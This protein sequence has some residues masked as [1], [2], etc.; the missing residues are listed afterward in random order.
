MKTTKTQFE[1]FKKDCI[2]WQESLGLGSWRL[3][4]QH[5]ALADSISAKTLWDT[6]AKKATIVLNTSIKSKDYLPCDLKATACHEVLHVLLA[7]LVSY[8]RRTGDEVVDEAEH[9]IINHLLK[10]FKL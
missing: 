5:A 1:Q 2:T 3:V 7:D 8:T 6:Q 9:V 10:A 4:F